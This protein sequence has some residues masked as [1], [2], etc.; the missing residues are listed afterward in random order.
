MA[1]LC[2]SPENTTFTKLYSL[3]TIDD[4]ALGNVVTIKLEGDFSCTHNTDRDSGLLG[5]LEIEVCGPYLLLKTADDLLEFVFCKRHL[6]ED[7]ESLFGGDALEVFLTGCDDKACHIE[8]SWADKELG[9]AFSIIA[10]RAVF[11]AWEYHGEVFIVMTPA[12]DIHHRLCLVVT[13]WQRI[14]KAQEQ[15]FVAIL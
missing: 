7:A 4:L 10:V 14:I 6:M 9:I 1:V 13:L 5:Y 11:P 12:D 15:L 3:W 2:A 8:G